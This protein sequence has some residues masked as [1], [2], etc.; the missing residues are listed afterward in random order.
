MPY[1]LEEH[2]YVVSSPLHR[3]MFRRDGDVVYMWEPEFFDPDTAY[4]FDL[5]TVRDL[6]FVLTKLLEVK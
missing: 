5:A 4:E 2:D 6:I 3:L 1:E